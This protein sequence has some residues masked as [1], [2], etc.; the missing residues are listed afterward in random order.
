MTTGGIDDRYLDL[1]PVDLVHQI[2][3]CFESMD[4]T[5]DG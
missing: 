1:I 4:E 2:M 3:R 5:E